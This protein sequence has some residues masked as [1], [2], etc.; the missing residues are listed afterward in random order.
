ML[1]IRQDQKDALSQAGVGGVQR[2]PPRPGEIET[3]RITV[4]QGI[5]FNNSDMNDSPYCQVP[6][7]L[8][9]KR[10]DRHALWK[11]TKY[12]WWPACMV[13]RDP[14]PLNITSGDTFEYTSKAQGVKFVVDIVNT[15]FEFKAALMSADRHVI[16]GGHARYGRGPCF[17]DKPDKGENWEDGKDPPWGLF[18]MGY[19]FIGIPVEEVFDHGYTVNLASSDVP[20][21]IEQAEPDLRPYVPALKAKTAVEIHKDLPGVAKDKDA[22]KTWWTYQGLEGGKIE[23][24]IVINAGWENTTVSPDDLGGIQPS[25]RVF[26]HFGCDTFKHN[27]SIL[28]DPSFKN[29]RRN[30]DDRFAY[31]TTSISYNYTANLWLYH[32]FTYQIYNAFCAWEPSLSYALARTNVDLKTSNESYRIV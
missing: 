11:D 23:T 25:C 20:V 14:L 6:N 1:K 3:R 28:R 30:G 27:H 15:K 17:G 4:A 13:T 26:C 5:E 32:L 24:F 12:K 9:T 16:Y 10:E 8:T 19:P 31:W 18:R 2:C 22:T 7:G 21:T 29:W